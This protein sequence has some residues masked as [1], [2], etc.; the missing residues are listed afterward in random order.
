MERHDALPEAPLEYDSGSL[1]TFQSC[2]LIV[3]W[4]VLLFCRSEMFLFVGLVF[5]KVFGVLFLFLFL[6][7][8]N[9]EPWCCPMWAVSAPAFLRPPPPSPLT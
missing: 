8:E 2:L 9:C 3:P 6:L 1:S 5:N 7:Q 4:V